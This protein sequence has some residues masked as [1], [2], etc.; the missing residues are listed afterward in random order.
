MQWQIQAGTGT[1]D[2]P[3]KQQQA[4]K[5]NFE[6]DQN[7]LIEQS[8]RYSNRTVTACTTIKHLLSTY[9]NWHL[10]HWEHLAS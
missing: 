6:Q 9:E 4:Y 2:S 3:Q 5:Q 8:V 1:C 10:Q 7:T